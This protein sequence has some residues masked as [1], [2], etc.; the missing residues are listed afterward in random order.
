[1]RELNLAWLEKAA[2]LEHLYKHRWLGERFFHL[3]GDM[4]ALQEIMWEVKPK[5][6]V[7]TGIAAGG[8]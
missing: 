2:P 7:H 1:M 6:V 8:R 5:L 3:P 4:V